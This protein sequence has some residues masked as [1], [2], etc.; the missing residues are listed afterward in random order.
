MKKK[1]ETL[2]ES[3]DNLGDAMDALADSI[4]D[5]LPKWMKGGLYRAVTKVMAYAFLPVTLYFVVRIVIYLI[6]GE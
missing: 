5:A 4:Y 6:L 3:L 2:K 1:P